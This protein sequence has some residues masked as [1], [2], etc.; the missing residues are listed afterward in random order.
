MQ[1][2]NVLSGIRILD[3]SRYIAGPYCAALLGYLG[4]DVIRVEKPGGSED[5]FVVP[6]GGDGGAVFAQSAGDKRSLCLDLKHPRAAEIVRRLVAS[7]DV[8]IVNH[9]PAGL[10]KLG[11]DYETLKAIKA[12]IILTTQTA[13]GHEGPWAERGGFDGIGQVM[14]GAAHFSGTQG[15]PA[16]SSA[17]YVDFGTALYSAFGTL[18]ALYQ[19]RDTG[20]G[21]H[22]QASLLGTA[23]T[24]FS[25]LLIE[26]AALTANRVPS[27]NRSQTSAPSDIFATSDGH[28]LLHVVGNGIF[29]RLCKA[30]G[31]DDWL[32][33]AA[34]Q[35]DEDRGRARDRICD[36]VA[37]WCRERSVE[38]V[39]DRMAEAGV[40]CGP[41][42]DPAAAMRHPQVKAMEFFKRLQMQGLVGGA[43][44]A[45]FPVSMSGAAV[46]LRGPMPRT[47]EHGADILAE[48]GYDIKEIA[49]LRRLGAFEQIAKK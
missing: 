21:Q 19:R 25:P 32:K 3:F 39:L 6:L 27:G 48:I 14:S 8:V 18:A 49:Q 17:A 22:V 40:P 13:Y 30:L 16:K 23:M 47:G 20:Q 44:V 12:D 35:N 24:F 15:E 34:L 2:Q 41:V 11:L 36:Q 29:T 4:A 46:G 43:E 9:P 28:V 26:Q 10:R 38:A 1:D 7:A 42:L 33:D 5:R 31:R 37:A 45:D